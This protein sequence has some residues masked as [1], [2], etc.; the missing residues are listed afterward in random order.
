M[1]FSVNIMTFILL[2]WNGG[3]KGNSTFLNAVD[4]ICFRSDWAAVTKKKVYQLRR[5]VQKRLRLCQVPRP[6]DTNFSVSGQ[7]KCISYS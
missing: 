6:E 2:E 1:V 3:N 7:Q 5:F 4:S